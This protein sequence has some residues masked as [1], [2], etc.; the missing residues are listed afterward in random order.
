MACKCWPIQQSRLLSETLKGPCVAMM[1][2]TLAGVALCIWSQDLD[3]DMIFFFCVFVLTAVAKLRHCE[4]DA[5]PIQCFFLTL[6]I[7]QSTLCLSHA[8]SLY[9]MRP[10]LIKKVINVEISLPLSPV[11]SIEQHPHRPWPPRCHGNGGN[12]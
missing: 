8:Q 4:S 1:A 5:F 6:R 2:L 7:V 3:F 11:F 10:D 9:S 12:A